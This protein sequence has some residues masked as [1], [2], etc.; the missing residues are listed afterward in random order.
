MEERQ[1]K[2]TITLIK[3]GPLRVRG[4]FTISDDSNNQIDEGAE[5]FLCR[6]GMSSKKPYCDGSH[7]S[8]NSE[9]ISDKESCD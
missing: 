9:E 1:S 8:L 2:P 5:V 3:N 7:K 4:N 6:C